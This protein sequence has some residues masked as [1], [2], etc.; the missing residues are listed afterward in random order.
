MIVATIGRV[1]AIEAI[2]DADRI[3]SV[4]VVCG[5]AGKWRG[6]CKKGEQQVGNLCEVYLQD[7]LLPQGERFAFMERSQ[8]RVRMSRFRGAVSECLIMPLTVDGMI[9]D[10]IG[11]RVGVVKYEKPVPYSVGG[12][13][14]AAFPSFLPKTDE[15]NFQAVPEL[16]QSMR[17]KPFYCTVKADGTSV[18]VYRH[19]GHFGVCSRN[20]EMKETDGNA[21]WQ[22]AKRYRLSYT[23]P[24]GMA[25]QFEGV[26]PGIQGNPMGLAELEARLFNVIYID[27]RRYGSAAE[28]LQAATSLDIPTV[29]IE[30]YGGILDASDDSL[31]RRAEG[32][33]LNGRQRE[34]I[35]IRSLESFPLFAPDRPS[36]K[37]INLLYK[38]S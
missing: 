30:S 37:V 21:L 1:V 15:M 27:E 10:D 12:D 4:T 34:G 14:L 9:G 17:G 22:L 33:Y 2:P 31:Q 23:L 29:W 7:A 35:V 11:E 24:E 28:L 32:T 13:I 26:G 25:L 8:W 3:E 36:F 5:A 6:V 19:E 38:E 16:V 18:T 20:W